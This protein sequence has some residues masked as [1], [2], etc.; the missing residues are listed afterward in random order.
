[1]PAKQLNE[2]RKTMTIVFAILLFSFLIFIHELGHFLA[3]KLSGVQV[4]EFA[5]FMGPAIFKWQRGETLYSIRCIPIGGY[6]AMEGEDEKS[7]NPRAFGSA[8]WWKRLIILVAGSF[9]NFVAGILIMLI[10]FMPSKQFVVP[11]IESFE[12][13]ST[14]TGENGLQPGDKILEVDGEKVYVQS[15]FSML[16]ALNPGDTHDI[17]VERNGERVFLEDLKMQ[18]H[19]VTDENGNTQMLYGMNFTLVDGSLPMKL[20]Y[21]WN[22][23]LNTVRSVRL[24]LQMLLSGQAGL[25][26]MTGPVGIV[27]IMSNTAAASD[28][29]ADAVLNMLYFGGF[30]AINLAV[31]NMLPIPALD[32]GRVV[33]LLLTTAVEGITKKK[34]DPKYEGYIHGAGMILLLGLMA[35]VMFKDIFTIFKG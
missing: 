25:K 26:D 18:T 4:N 16:L 2:T 1:M 20:Q 29:T 7:D 11:V 33:A 22:T 13:Y 24:S 35:V 17:T 30:I 34:I 3:A 14:V 32:G 28:T 10:V 27:Q 9:M 21:S 23:A 15:D 12:S 31:M 19:P 8:K 5:I 6:C